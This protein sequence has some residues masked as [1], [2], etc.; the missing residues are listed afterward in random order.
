MVGKKNDKNFEKKFNKYDKCI[1][2]K[3][4]QNANIVKVQIDQTLKN[5]TKEKLLQYSKTDKSNFIKIIKYK[6]NYY[7]TGPHSLQG[8]E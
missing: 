1:K 4:P 5:Y 2:T 8:R 6:S 3:C 7:E